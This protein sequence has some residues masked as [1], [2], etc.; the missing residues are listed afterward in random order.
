MVKSAV[1]EAC[2]IGLALQRRDTGVYI[3]EVIEG[4]TASRCPDEILIGDQL[5]Q[6]P[7]RGA[8]H[9]SFTPHIAYLCVCVWL[10]V[11]VDILADRIITTRARV[12]HRWTASQLGRISRGQS[13]SSWER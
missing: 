4:G 8:S 11:R 13:S 1:R 12:L 5:L 3:H 9:L 2:G 7:L 10:C 6:V